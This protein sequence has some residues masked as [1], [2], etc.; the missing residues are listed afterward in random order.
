MSSASILATIEFVDF[1][2]KKLSE[3]ATPETLEFSKIRI[4][5]SRIDLTNSTVE[6]SLPS[7]KIN[8]SDVG[9][10]AKR[11]DLTDERIVASPFFTGSSTDIFFVI[12]IHSFKEK[13]V[14][15][16]GCNT[17]LATQNCILETVENRNQ[18]F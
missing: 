5:S 10:I 2:I 4:L 3:S 12:I 17:S 18:N 7:L 9:D 1:L 13:F 6:S 16:V 11:V 8:N 14:S 15:N